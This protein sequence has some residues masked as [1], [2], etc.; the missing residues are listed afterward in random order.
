MGW[1]RLFYCC[2]SHPSGAA[3]LFVT[4]GRNALPVMVQF[5]GSP[6][7]G[8]TRLTVTFTNAST[9]PTSITVWECSLGDGVTGTLQNPS[10][11]YQLAGSY[12]AQMSIQTEV[13]AARS[14]NTSITVLSSPPPTTT[15]ITY[16]YDGLYRLTRAVHSTG[17][18]F[19]YAYDAVG[20]RVTYTHTFSSQ[21]VKT[22]AYDAANRLTSVDGQ[23][24][25]W[26]N[27]GNL[28][29]DG[30]KDYVYDQANR[31][32]NINANGLAWGAV[33]N[34]DGARLR[35]VTNGVPT[36]YT[37]DLNAGLVQVL[38]MQDAGGTT[39]YMYGVTRIGEQQPGAWAYH[40]SDA[41]GSVRQL[42]DD[43]A[44]VTLARGYMPYGEPLWSV[45]DG[46]SAYGYTGE[47]WN[48]TTQLVF[49]RA[50]YMQPGLGMFLS[51]DPWSGDDL[52]PESMNGWNYVEGNPINRTDPSG[53]SE[54]DPG[55]GCGGSC[56]ID[57]SF[58]LGYTI[59][60]DK[61]L[62]FYKDQRFFFSSPSLDKMNCIF[63]Q[64][65]YGVADS[66]PH[67]PNRPSDMDTQKNGW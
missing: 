34:G 29:N 39:A 28:L 16:A 32:T 46:N 2:Q 7:T 33:Y 57:A 53:A 64:W 4:K 54:S 23:A 65:I 10:H 21:A 9:A 19:E 62:G 17:E 12:P 13:E 11:T 35:Q 24:Y 49:L 6:L 61:K 41:L 31:L 50:R 58:D 14:G 15:V 48:T 26:D 55:G 56:E 66:L 44:Q 1:W 40:L 63:V 5:T 22:Y 38:T 37:L 8:S 52:R 59:V 25:T 27:N 3:F 42:A 36:T 67:P 47:D 20:N 18:S 51:H 43:A 60:A 45:G 30:S